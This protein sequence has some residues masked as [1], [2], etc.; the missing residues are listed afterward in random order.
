MKRVND[1]FDKSFT[2]ESA[3]YD[4]VLTGK[5]WFYRLY[6]RFFWGEDD[7][8]AS[9]DEVLAMLPEDFSGALLD[10]PAGTGVFTAEKY[11]RLKSARIECVD[12][13]KAMLGRYKN[14]VRDEDARH[15]RF[16]RGDV[17]CLHFDDEVFDI[18]L[19]M[20]GY[21]CFPEKEKALREICRVTKRGGR[22][23]GC[24]YVKGVSARTDFLVKQ[25]YDRKGFFVPPHETA[26][27]FERHLKR[28]FTVDRYVL[29]NSAACFACRRP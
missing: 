12:Y 8:L 3:L 22:F 19:S 23:V 18:V 27:A 4:D 24:A 13:S 17:G 7:S 14:R 11:L 26:E 2:E 16:S 29:I 6:N 5:Y 20:N 10:V 9:A 1:V 15:I 25:I 28:R 21:H